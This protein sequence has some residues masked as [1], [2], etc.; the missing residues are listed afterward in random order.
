MSFSVPKR[1][2][3]VGAAKTTKGTKNGNTVYTI[4]ITTS[5]DRYATHSD[6]SS[7][8]LVALVGENDDS[9]LKFVPTSAEA[10]DTASTEA[11]LRE[12]CAGEAEDVPPGADCSL[13]MGS[14]TPTVSR[15]NKH[16]FLSGTTTEVSFVSP[17]LGPLSA[18]IVGPQSGTWGCSEVVVS[19]SADVGVASSKFLS[20][21]R[22]GILGQ[23]VLQSA[24]YLVRVPQGSIVYGEGMYRNALF[25]LRSRRDD[26]GHPHL[27]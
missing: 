25:A 1:L 14:P 23:D 7:G 8:I 10:S 9:V 17:D 16:R 4:R 19:S 11:M 3:G 22:G 27:I 2:L 15:Y 18:V 20:K 26:F 21:D 6:T 5:S 12:M 13:I 24:S